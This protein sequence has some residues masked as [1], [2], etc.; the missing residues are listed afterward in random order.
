MKGDVRH[1][2]AGYATGTL[3]DAEKKE[4]FEAA[5]HDPELFAEIAGEE[6]LRELLESAAVR[7][8]LLE[9]IEPASPGFREQLVGWLRRPGVLAGAAAAVLVVVAVSVAPLMR[10]KVLHEVALEVNRPEEILAP[11][12]QAAPERKSAPAPAVQKRYSVPSVGSKAVRPP[13]A[14]ADSARLEAGAPKPPDGAVAGGGTPIEVLPAP[15]PV[16]APAPVAFEVPSSS[17]VAAQIARESSSPSLRYEVE[18]RGPTG[19]FAA[20]ANP[21]ELKD[22]DV[23]RVRFRPSRTGF[24]TV[25]DTST[26]DAAPLFSGQVAAGSEVVTETVTMDHDRK[27]EVL[28]VPSTAGRYSSALRAHSESKAAGAVPESTAPTT[29]FVRS[30]KLGEAGQSTF[31][32]EL[33]RKP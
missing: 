20:T 30:L 8:E 10:P 21:P 33:R 27:L 2:L 19:E 25:H 31:S 24:L 9:R 29:P 18:T 3:T 4:L 6:P 28:F 22:R 5:L 12:P 23:V 1:L 13:Q 14:F 17:L 15:P 16:S 7:A 11:V 32:I 26:P